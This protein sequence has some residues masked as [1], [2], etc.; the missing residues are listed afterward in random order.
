MERANHEIMTNKTG[1]QP[2]SRPVEQVHYFGGWV[3]GSK[4]LWYQGR[5]VALERALD[6]ELICIGHTTA[7]TFIHKKYAN[8]LTNI[9]PLFKK[10]K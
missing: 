1:L 8:S 9:A 10:E 3:N 6:L 7:C 2:V 4:S 5:Y